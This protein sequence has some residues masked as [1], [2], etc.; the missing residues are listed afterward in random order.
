MTAQQLAAMR[1]M[2][3]LDKPDSAIGR[4]YG[5]TRQRV[6]QILG[7]R[8]ATPRR[9][10]PAAPPAPTRAEFAAALLSWRHRRGLSQAQ[11]AR[12]LRVGAHSVASWEQQSNGCSLAGAVMLLLELMP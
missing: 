8:P 2:R 1:A 6:H 5:L 10:P 4:R 9:A 11:A 12:I 3:A 7:K